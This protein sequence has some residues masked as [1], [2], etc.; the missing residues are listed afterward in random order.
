MFNTLR[1]IWGWA[2]Q[3]LPFQWVSIPNMIAPVRRN[4]DALDNF[5]CAS[6]LVVTWNGY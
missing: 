1:L 5:R 3:S 4:K 2:A 6:D